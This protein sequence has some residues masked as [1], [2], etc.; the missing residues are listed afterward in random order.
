MSAGQEGE[1]DVAVVDGAIDEQVL[2]DFATWLERVTR[3][4]AESDL[5]VEPAA[6]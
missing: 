1:I 2:R 4:Q 5:P 6:R 3:Q